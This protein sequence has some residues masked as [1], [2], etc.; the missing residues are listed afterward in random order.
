MFLN[1]ESFV[2]G[3]WKHSHFLL[4]YIPLC[5]VVKRTRARGSLTCQGLS[6]I[7]GFLFLSH[8][9]D[10]CSAQTWH[11]GRETQRSMAAEHMPCAL[12]QGRVLPCAERLSSPHVASVPPDL[13]APPSGFCSYPGFLWGWRDFGSHVTLAIQPC[14]QGL[15][16]Q[17]DACPVLG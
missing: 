3:F 13:Y 9:T 1:I 16:F 17:K 15:V 14:Y 7:P 10:D 5:S 11:R 4:K 8:V 6:S 12:A 2:A